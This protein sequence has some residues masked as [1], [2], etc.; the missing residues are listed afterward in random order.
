MAEFFIAVDDDDNVALST[1]SA[2]D[3]VSNLYDS[4]D[5]A[6]IVKV[7]CFLVNFTGTATP[8]VV[9]NIPDSCDEVSVSIDQSAEV[10]SKV[11]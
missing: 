10:S 8:K 7:I 4:A 5:V 9:V 6:G 3:A 1:E 11:S 2:E